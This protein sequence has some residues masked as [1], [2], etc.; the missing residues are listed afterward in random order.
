MSLLTHI[1]CQITFD[2]VQ[3]ILRRS[4]KVIPNLK[5]DPHNIKNRN[6]S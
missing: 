3:S 5:L 4:M 2:F 1:V 6:N